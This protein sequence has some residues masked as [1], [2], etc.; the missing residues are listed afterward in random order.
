ME[1]VPDVLPLWKQYAVILRRWGFSVWT[2]IL[3]AA[4]YGVPQ[5]RKRAILPASRVRTAQPPSRPGQLT[6]KSKNPR[7]CSGQ[8]APAGSAW[9][10]PWAGERPT[11]LCPSSAPAADPAAAPS[12]SLPAPERLRLPK[13]TVHRRR[14]RHLDTPPGHPLPALQPGRN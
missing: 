8:A 11:G 14:P 10:R 2:G 4:D 5:T 9:R 1:E 12:P 6:P 3:N 13:G 7:G